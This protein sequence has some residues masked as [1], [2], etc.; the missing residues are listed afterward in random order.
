MTNNPTEMRQIQSTVREN[1]MLE[2][3]IATTDVPTP[4]DS[5]VL[6]RI[7]AAPINPSD[8]GALFGP[9]DMD[10]ASYS[11]SAASPSIQAPIPLHLMAGIEGRIGQSLPVGNEGGGTVVAAGS[12]ELAQSLIGKVVG[13]SGGGSYSE[14][15]AVRAEQCVVMPDGIRPAAAASC[16]VNPMTVLGFVGT[17]RREGHSAMVHTAAASNLGQML[18]KIALEEDFNLVNIVRTTEQEKILRNIGGRFIC[19]SSLESFKSDLTD[20]LVETGAT[21]GFDATGGGKL[22]SD[23]LA[24]MERAAVSQEAGFSRYGSTVHKQVYIYGGLDRSVTVLNRSFGMAWGIGGWLLTPYLQIVGAEEAQNMRD[25]VASSITTTFASS[26]AK[27]VSLTEALS[28][29]AVDEYR[30]QAT[31]QKFLINPSLPS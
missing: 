10:K 4:R 19:N 9:A 24:C 15:K 29:G 16:F 22:T 7:E 23:I 26:Y 12:S 8:L 27:E 20:A 31:G 17:M 28:Q 6:V 5:D 11:G 25:R 13:F 2:L 21:L 3:R 1:E 14:Y 30:K 18:Q